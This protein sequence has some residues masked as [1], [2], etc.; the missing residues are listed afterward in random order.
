MQLP[1]RENDYYWELQLRDGQKISVPPAGVPIVQRKMSAKEA[2]PTSTMTIPYADIVRFV[3]TSR[4]FTDVKLIE[5]AARAFN[6]P[7]YTEDGAIKARWVKRQV[8]PQEYSSYYAK[9]NYRR[10]GEE[11]GMVWVAF[12]LPVHKIDFNKVE[13]C[14]VEE[15][16]NLH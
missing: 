15:E 14:T 1:N 9:G 11:D 12:V 6:E 13:Y 4:R 3:K 16:R 5:D 10:L 2:I 8:T 7:V